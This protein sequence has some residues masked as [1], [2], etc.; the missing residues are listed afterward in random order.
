MKDSRSW[1]SERKVW[2]VILPNKAIIGVHAADRTT[3][4]NIVADA[5]KNRYG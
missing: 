3:A 1:K 4:R 2:K 5:K